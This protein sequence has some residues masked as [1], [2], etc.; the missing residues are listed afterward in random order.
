[1]VSTRPDSRRR[2]AACVQSGTSKTI[3]R[4]A[5]PMTSLDRRGLGGWCRGK[6]GEGLYGDLAI[7][8]H[9]R[10]RRQRDEWLRLPHDIR[11]I[12]PDVLAKERQRANQLRRRVAQESV[13]ERA[14]GIH[15]RYRAVWGKQHGALRVVA[16]DRF[17]VL[18]EG[19]QMVVEG[20]LSRHAML[21]MEDSATC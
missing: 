14:Y 7:A 1:M 12:A 20:D 13:K 3:S 18:T 11:D 15:A 4:L 16:H 19:I 8:D 10:V 2:H 5:A 9:E 6:N 17:D 21:R